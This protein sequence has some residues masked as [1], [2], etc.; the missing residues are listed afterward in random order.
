MRLVS[1]GLPSS[2]SMFPLR[3]RYLPP[4]LCT[5]SCTDA[6]Y[7]LGTHLLSRNLDV[8]DHVNGHW[9]LLCFSGGIGCPRLLPDLQE[10]AGTVPVQKLSCLIQIRYWHAPG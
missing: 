2:V 7:V 1:R 8:G 10:N 5:S 4:C 3:D 6:A 9:L